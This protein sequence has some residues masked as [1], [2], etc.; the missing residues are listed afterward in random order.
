MRL[1]RQPGGWWPRVEQTI[2]ARGG[3]GAERTPPEPK[4]PRGCRPRD[5]RPINGAG[6][7]EDD[8]VIG[9]LHSSALERRD[10]G[11]RNRSLAAW[12]SISRGVC[13]QPAAWRNGR[14]RPTPGWKTRATVS[15]ITEY[16]LAVVLPQTALTT[17]SNSATSPCRSPDYSASEGT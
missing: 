17:A 8:G 11:S 1:L 16:L 4:G 5:G 13:L 6:S 2:G 7:Q 9:Q 3:Q 12:D 10:L 14:C 15:L